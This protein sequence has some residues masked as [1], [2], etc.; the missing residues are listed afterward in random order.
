MINEFVIC[1]YG[2]I[3]FESVRDKD[4]YYNHV[5]DKAIIGPMGFEYFFNEAKYKENN[6]CVICVSINC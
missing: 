1:S 2:F 3:H 4:R 5:R 6:V